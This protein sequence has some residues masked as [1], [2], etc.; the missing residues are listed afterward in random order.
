VQ[1]LISRGYT[2][3]C[4]GTCLVAYLARCSS[5]SDISDGSLHKYLNRSGSARCRA[6]AILQRIL[7]SSTDCWSAS[8]AVGRWELADRW[9]EPFHR[10]A[11]TSIS[12]QQGDPSK[13][14]CRYRGTDLCGTRSSSSPFTSREGGGTLQPPRRLVKA[15]WRLGRSSPK[16]KILFRLQ[17]RLP[18]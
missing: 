14:R 10:R 7:V 5:V 12:A 8:G 11:E 1:I 16:Q 4:M 15:P 2:G 13:R 9:N 3:R 18:R 6:M 17:L